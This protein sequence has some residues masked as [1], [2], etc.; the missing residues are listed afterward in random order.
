MQV[1]AFYIQCKLWGFFKISYVLYLFGFTEYVQSEN[2]LQTIWS[3]IAWRFTFEYLV[4][5]Y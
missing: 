2:E 4:I 5:K 3:A 1:L